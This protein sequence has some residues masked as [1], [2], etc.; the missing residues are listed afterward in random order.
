MIETANPSFLAALGLNAKLFVAQLINFSIVL[1]VVWRW[2]YKPLLKVMDKRAQTIAGG[3][4]NAEKAQKT[5][6]DVERKTETML[7]EAQQVSQKII[8]EARV[9]AG[10]ER[11]KLTAETQTELERQLADA[12]ER[13]KADKQAMLT[14]IKVEVADLIAE[15]TQ[16]VMSGGADDEAQRKL[17]KEA[18]KEVEKQA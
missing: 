3:L 7:T 17:I 11:K 6:A 4:E 8:E 2:I 18:I 16:K 5:L 10:L 1:Y 12:R 9:E 14:S 15:A 13:L